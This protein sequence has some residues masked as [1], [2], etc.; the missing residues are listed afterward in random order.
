MFL[1]S[2]FLRM[3]LGGRAAKVAA[4]ATTAIA[5]I[6]LLGALWLWLGARE[7]A[8]DKANQDLGRQVQQAEDMAET[9]DRV[10]RANDAEEKLGDPDARRDGCLRHSRTPSNC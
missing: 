4:Y 1:I 9:I 10:E 2:L 6:A 5:V 8:D 7:E 3:G